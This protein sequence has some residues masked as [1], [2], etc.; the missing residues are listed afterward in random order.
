MLAVDRATL[1]AIGR[2]SDA[3][4][5][6]LLVLGD[7]LDYLDGEATEAMQDAIGAFIGMLEGYCDTL[8]PRGEA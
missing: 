4:T 5:D 3:A 8:S 1:K 6:A 2:H 7:L